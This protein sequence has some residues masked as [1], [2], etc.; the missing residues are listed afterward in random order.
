MHKFEVWA[1]NAERVRVKVNGRTQALNREERSWWR[2]E[3]EDAGPGTDYG[4]LLD[5]DETVLPDPRSNYQPAGIHGPSRIV[6]H[7]AF[8]WNDHHWQAPPL[9]GAVIYELHV[10]TFAPG[11]DFDSVAQC[12]DYL[13]DM[14]VTHIE[15]MPVNEFAGPR[16]WGYDGVDLYATHHC[17]GGPDGLK[18]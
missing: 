9:S 10:G 3:V 13:V 7:S 1:P 2:V 14:G 8:Q 16:G 12:L 17:Y 15:L 5:E 11:G 4:F 6:N 18:R